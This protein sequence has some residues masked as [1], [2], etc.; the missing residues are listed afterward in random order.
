MVWPFHANSSPVKQNEDKIEEQVIQ[1]LPKDLGDFLKAKNRERFRFKDDTVD[2]DFGSFKKFY[3]PNTISKTNCAEFEQAIMDCFDK[4]ST[5]EK[6]S[7]CKDQTTRLTKCLG[8]QKIVINKLGVDQIESKDKFY[9]IEQV[10]D[11]IGLKW[12]SKVEDPNILPQEIL[13]DI[14]E[15][16]DEIWKES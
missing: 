10:A 12:E 13:D 2:E 7:M 16:R 6:L 8:F 3:N 4:G 5:K 1:E 9:K 14:Y 11:D 15:K